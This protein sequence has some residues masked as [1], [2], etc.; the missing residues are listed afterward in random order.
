MHVCCGGAHAR[1]ALGRCSI[2]E[3][4]RCAP[5]ETLHAQP[6]PGGLSVFLGQ[7]GVLMCGHACLMHGTAKKGCT[8][9]DSGFL[10]LA[11]TNACAP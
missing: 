2:P 3:L 1:L 10:Q 8:W 5:E 9:A 11:A 6:R 4:P 7:E